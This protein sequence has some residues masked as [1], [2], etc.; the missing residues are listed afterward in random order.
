MRVLWS[1]P[2]A[3][4]ISLHIFVVMMECGAT[5]AGLDKK[6]I[7]QTA[8]VFVSVQLGMQSL[9]IVATWLV[10]R[11]FQIHLLSR[12]YKYTTFAILAGIGCHRIRDAL[13]ADS[14]PEERH[15]RLSLWQCVRISA[16]TGGEA[17]A[18][19]MSLY[20]YCSPW[21]GICIVCLAF[22]AALA[23]FSYGYLNGVTR[24]R[25]LCTAD[26][27]LMAALAVSIVL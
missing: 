22:F 14:L 27:C 12:F 15:P 20:Y 10:E 7:L 3:I 21:S 25:F 23:G 26:G 19:G 6:R 13:R 16:R 8:A 18:A 1:I 2:V 24:R 17:L 5:Q 4:G 9:G 11:V